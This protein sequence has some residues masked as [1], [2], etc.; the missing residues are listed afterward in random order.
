MQPILLIMLLLHPSATHTSST[1]F[2][3]SQDNAD[4]QIM[5]SRSGHRE[6]GL[7]SYHTF[8]AILNVWSE[9]PKII[10]PFKLILQ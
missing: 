3:T 6:I 8:V 10:N 7:D 5:S 9:I 2:A 1:H 4:H